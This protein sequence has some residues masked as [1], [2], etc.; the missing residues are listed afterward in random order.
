MC[1]CVCVC[2]CMYV[3]MCLYIYDS[4]DDRYIFIHNIKYYVYIYGDRVRGDREKVSYNSG[5]P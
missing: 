4:M 3:C 1:V 5:W 2:V